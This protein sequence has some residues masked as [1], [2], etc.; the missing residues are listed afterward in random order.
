M[1]E[2]GKREEEMK[3]ALEDIARRYDIDDVYVFGSRAAEVAA[4]VQEAVPPGKPSRSDVDIGVL[5]I[6]GIHLNAERRVSLAIELED[7]FGAPRVD[8]VILPEADPFL[9]LDVI[10]GELIYARDLDRQAEYELLALRRA[11]DLAPFQKER[12]RMIF[13]EKGR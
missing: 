5:P 1:N 11:A 10:R 2:F 3:Q 9:V 13:E 7:L 8:L 4:R 12:I 6:A